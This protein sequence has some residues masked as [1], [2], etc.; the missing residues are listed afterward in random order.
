MNTASVAMTH[1]IESAEQQAWSQYL[2]ALHAKE[3]AW[4]ARCIAWGDAVRN[5]LRGDA[6][7]HYLRANDDAQVC[8]DRET[9]ARRRWK[10]IAYPL[11]GLQLP[12]EG[13]PDHGPGS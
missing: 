13:V 5:Q 3:A 1:N 4:T 7:Q 9:E 11:Y 8:G 6:M 2:A 10:H 12:D